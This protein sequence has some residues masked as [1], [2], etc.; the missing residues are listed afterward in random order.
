[1]TFSNDLISNIAYAK[2]G[3]IEEL[4]FDVKQKIEEIQ[5]S[6]QHQ[7]QFNQQNSTNQSR[8]DS[9]VP[10]PHSFDMGFQEQQPP[11]TWQPMANQQF[12][13]MPSYGYQDH[14]QQQ[15][16]Q[17]QQHPLILQQAANQLMHPMNAYDIPQS[18][19]VPYYN[20]FPS[21]PASQPQSQPPVPTIR[22]GKSKSKKP[23]IGQSSKPAEELS[24]ALHNDTYSKPQEKDQIISDLQETIEVN[25]KEFLFL[26]LDRISKFRF[27]N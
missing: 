21:A 27:Y 8:L 14:H 3:F 5:Q 16:Q 10:L 4:L 13:G 12:T 23:S 15:Q 11:Q 2:A 26:F 7:D 25:P 9:N 22:S 24:K 20:A 17:Q 6:F 1:M 19:Q 18:S